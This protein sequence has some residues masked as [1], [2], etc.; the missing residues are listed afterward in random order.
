MENILLNVWIEMKNGIKVRLMKNI[1]NYGN[2]RKR[3]DQ[4]Y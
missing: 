1:F 4:E 2:K 3:G